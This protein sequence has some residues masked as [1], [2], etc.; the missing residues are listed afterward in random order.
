MS[1][2][3][4][5]AATTGF[6]GVD[7]RLVEDGPSGPLPVIGPLGR[8]PWQV[9]ARPFAPNAEKAR[10]AVV[11][12][13]LGLSTAATGKAV[14]SLPPEVSLA[15]LSYA[16]AA[17]VWLQRAR[18]D[19]HEVLIAVPM[20]PA[21]KTDDPGP[22]ALT[23]AAAPDAMIDALEWHLSRGSAYVGIATYMG[24]AFLS[25]ESA[26]RTI[27]APLRDRGLLLFDASATNPAIAA[28]VT[29]ELGVPFAAVD[30]IIDP[31]PSRAAVDRRLAEVEEIARRRGSAIA[32][33]RPYPVTI[34]AIAAWAATLADR[35]FELAPLSAMVGGDKPSQ[36]APNAAPDATPAPASARKARP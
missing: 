15:F 16:D 5:T 30:R 34:D 19:G 10:I 9:Y 7:P 11:L 28:R 21:A 33:G 4:A 23:T 26:V 31:V 3:A 36:P 32:L 2:D 1:P 17:A 6:Q 13:D 14:N 35:G 20:E 27:V 18:A 22:R 24:G 8:K 29:A 25:T 12:S